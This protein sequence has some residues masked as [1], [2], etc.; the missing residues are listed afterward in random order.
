MQWSEY[1]ASKVASSNQATVALQGGVDQST[2]SRWLKGSRPPSPE[3]A[4]EFARNL[5]DSPIA[6]LIAAGHIEEDEAAQ[7]VTL[8]TSAS[9]L[10]DEQLVREVE[11]RIGHTVGR[12]RGA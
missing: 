7:V 4:I 10:S 12:R 5:G 11:R 2:V 9:D 3:K 6:A 8:R 1:V